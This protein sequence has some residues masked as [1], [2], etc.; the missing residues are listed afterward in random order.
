[1]GDVVS[2]NTV[3]QL[4]YIKGEMSSIPQTGK[5]LT[6]RFVQTERLCKEM[7]Q[8]GA[9]NQHPVIKAGLE[10]IPAITDLTCG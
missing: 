9:L 4:G 1:M 8:Q 2:E 5:P 7:V 3:A 6:C 10:M